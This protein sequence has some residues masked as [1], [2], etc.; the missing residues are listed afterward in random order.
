VTPRVAAR[1]AHRLTSCRPPRLLSVAAIERAQRLSDNWRAEC[2]AIIRRGVSST[3]NPHRD[4]STVTSARVDVEGS[5]QQRDALAHAR[6]AQAAAGQG[7][8][9][10]LSRVGHDQPECAVKAP[11]SDACTRGVAVR[12]H[13]VQSFLCHSIQAQGFVGTD[14][15]GHVCVARKRNRDSG[16]PRMLLAQDLQR[17]CQ[18]EDLQFQ[19]VQL[20]RNVV[21][22][23][24][25]LRDLARERLDPRSFSM[26]T[27]RAGD[28]I[29]IDLEQRKLLTD[30]VMQLPGDAGALGLLSVD[31]CQWRWS[32]KPARSAVRHAGGRATRMPQVSLRHRPALAS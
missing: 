6:Q 4:T 8:V 28:L 11:K 27:Q 19:G 20:I 12:H 1:W 17:S 23:P 15:V 25:N 30:A 24:C 29:Q 18:A 3:W 7:V 9:E 31:E 16:S 26:R 10:T 13:V 14:P 32:A 21:K 5:V 2:A 22:F